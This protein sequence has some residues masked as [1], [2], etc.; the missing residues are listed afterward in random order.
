LT[1]FIAAVVG[2]TVVGHTNPGIIEMNRHS[3]K[4][5]QKPSHSALQHYDL[6]EAEIETLLD[7]EFLEHAKSPIDHGELARLRVE[8]SDRKAIINRYR[9]L[10]LI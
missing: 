1:Q 8:I 10:G 4:G 3:P 5:D 6:L 7:A 2:C 9:S